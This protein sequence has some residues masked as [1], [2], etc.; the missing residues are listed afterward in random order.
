MR[1][2]K[3]LTVLALAAGMA[4]TTAGP[5][6]AVERDCADFASQA[7]AQAALEADP[8]DPEML[9]ADH[10]GLA[11][12]D[13]AYTPT[14]GTGGSSGEQIPTA[15]VGG[16]A[17][18]DGSTAGTDVLPFVVGGLGLAA[19]GGAAFAARRTARGSA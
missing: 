6:W 2:R 16:V 12:E 8:T 11:C 10:D 18:G 3:S 13:H 17:T 19:A 9:D 7:D 4:V 14:G 15:P 5:A 1:I